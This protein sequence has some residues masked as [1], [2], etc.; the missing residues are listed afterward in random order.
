M[1]AVHR[2]LIAGSEY[3]SRVRALR[4]LLEERGR[5]AALVWGR[6]GG[7]VDRCSDV[8]YLTGFYPVF[9]TIRDVPGA[10]RDRG[11]C[12]VL[13]TAD[14][15]V[16]LSDDPSAETAASGVTSSVV[17]H[18]I[19]DRSLAGDLLEEL[20]RR[21]E[22]ESL[23]LVAGDAMSGHHARA[24]LQDDRFAGL[25]I[26]WDD[27]VVE[28]L[29]WRKSDAEIRLMRRAA[30]IAEEALEAGF[31]KIAPGAAEAEV[32]AAMAAAVTRN[33][34]VLANAFVYTTSLDGEAEDNRLPIHSARRL[35]R[36]DVFTV[37]LS[38]VYA[39]Y[40]FDLARSTVVGAAPT[41]EQT[42]AYE[43]AKGVVDGVV[44][45]L[46]PGSRLGDASAV[47]TRMLREAGIDPDDAEFAARGH[48]LG[49][50]FESP[51]VRD[52]CDVMLE[53]GM[54]ISI[55]QFVTIGGTSATY[56]RNILI[57]AEGPED[58]VAVRDFWPA[59]NGREAE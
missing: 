12:A 40:F 24:L 20:G 15:V 58:L 43:L 52:D 57:G 49:L 16:L 23:V 33:E 41:A 21:P 18:G 7:S 27:G 9:P 59:S 1:S 5:D 51:W 29:R 54:I 22:I 53:T 55:E 47:G 19:S 13:V 48:G 34:A 35:C 14:E 30:E 45:H 36:G 17:R 10:W 8:R 25:E 11:L 42:R 44:E 50:G 39:G 4:G 6:G 2:D 31:A 3:Q 37:D 28:R 46:R 38:G 56:E 32:I 26:D